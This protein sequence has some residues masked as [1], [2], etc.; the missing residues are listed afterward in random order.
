VTEPQPIAVGDALAELVHQFADP[1]AFVRELVQNSVDAGT[2][3]IDVDVAFDPD[4]ASPNVGVVR[5]RVAD[6]G[7]GMTREII[8]KKLTRLFSSS[9]DGDRTKI[10]KFGIGF[11]SVFAL[12]PDLVCIDTA[13]D[14]EHWRVL[15]RKDRTFEL[16]RLT[17]PVEGT[18]I[19]L[20]KSGDAV[21]FAEVSTRV[22]Q[23]LRFWCEHVKCEVRFRG[24]SICAQFDL[25]DAPCRVAI[26]QGE[27][28]I[29]VG[30]AR[31]HAPAYGLYNEGLTLM[32]GRERYFDAIAFK[33]SSPLLEHTL[34]RDAVIEDDGYAQVLDI[35]TQTVDGALAERVFAML[36]EHHPNSEGTASSDH[37][38]LEYLYRAA[39]WHAARGLPDSV[40][41]RIVFATPSATP[42]RVRDCQRRPRGD[43][44]LFARE[45]APVTDDLE[46]RGHLLVTGLA[47][48][49]RHALAA[50]LAPEGTV[51]AHVRDRFCRPVAP[52]PALGPVWTKL[53]AL[54]LELLRASGSKAARVE[55]A[56][57]D[58]PDS[59]IADLVAI[60]QI[61]PCM[62]DE[63]HEIEDIAAGA[64][65]RR[66]TLVV[67]V[68]HPTVRELVA[69]AHGEPALAAY[70][71]AK[72]LSL[73]RTLDPCV[74]AKLA[75]EA[76]ARR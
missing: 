55:P 64:L 71:L 22:E 29:V 17:Q 39:A 70:L 45:R 65:A 32:C 68:G 72:A 28:R 44:V 38:Q 1:Y 31:D 18:R 2:S 47:G 6:D 13:R 25:P 74:D 42:L 30:H 60:A 59:P 35:V 56:A 46:A 14:G 20:L 41:Q 7:D 52:E 63:L 40:L 9:K 69:L 10:G 76:L 58:Y 3:A 48:G 34:T 66:R 53:A 19:E 57:F 43:I 27:T 4:P 37:A 50:A 11:V 73:G 51:V 21:L 15:F 61:E 67:N 8:E 26:T 62:L 54:A 23:S 36:E 5:V 16:I 33:A 49:G 24:R 12:D 75:T